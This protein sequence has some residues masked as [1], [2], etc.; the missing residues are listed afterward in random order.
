MMLRRQHPSRRTAF[1]LIELLVVIAIIGVLMAMTTAAVQRVRVAGKR[2]NAIGDINQLD[3]ACTKFKQDFGFYPPTRF[4][5]NTAAGLQVMRDMFPRWNGTNPHGNVTLDG[6]ESLVFFLGGPTGTGWAS[7]APVAPTG[8]AKKGPYF[9]FPENKLS[10]TS[11]KRQFLDPWGSAY[12]Y[13]GSDRAGRY[14]ATGAPFTPFTSGGKDV[15][16]GRIQIVCAG[17]NKQFGS[18]GVWSPGTG[19]YGQGQPGADDLANFNAGAALVS[20]GSQ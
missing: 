13:V 10:G 2:A 7:D 16:Q 19:V 4:Q 18:G 5:P 14:Q 12:G 8:T 3:T 20:A 11:P 6:I 1:T 15:N 9:D 17:P